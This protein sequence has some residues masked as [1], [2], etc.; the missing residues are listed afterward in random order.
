M[1]WLKSGSSRSDWGV[2]SGVGVGD[3]MGEVSYSTMSRYRL[4]TREATIGSKFRGI[5]RVIRFGGVR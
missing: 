4:T 2:V 3:G 5:L 1:T